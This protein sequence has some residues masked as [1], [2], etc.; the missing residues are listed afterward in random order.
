M[1]SQKRR[2]AVGGPGSGRYGG[3]GKKAVVEDFLSLDVQR[4]QR[5]GCLTSGR[6]FT[7][8]WERAGREV[9]SISVTA[10]RGAVEL[11]YTTTTP[12]GAR[13]DVCYRVYLTRTRCNFGG[14]RPW[15]V[16]PGVGCGRRIAKLYGPP[17]RYFL[18]RH[19]YDLSYRSRQEKPIKARAL[20]WAQ[21]FG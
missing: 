10:L 20:R 1:I 15:F 14:F 11:S 6:A 16:C 8:S 4:L 13:E 17:G 9:A 12:F 18:C 21:I 19:C 3:Y 5:E 2:Q 7:W